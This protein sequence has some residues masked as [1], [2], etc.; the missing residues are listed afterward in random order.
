MTLGFYAAGFADMT[1]D[2]ILTWGGETGYQAVELVCCPQATTDRVHAE[3]RRHGRFW[4]SEMGTNV[5]VERLD[6]AEAERIRERAAAAGLTISALGFYENHLHPDR[7]QRAANQTH[8]RR[9]IEAAV[10]L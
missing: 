9:T 5:D 6:A 7:S 2:E 8:L 3:I 10:L 4:S 1:L